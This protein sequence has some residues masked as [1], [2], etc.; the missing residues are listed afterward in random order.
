MNTHAYNEYVIQASLEAG[1]I[2]Q[3]QFLAMQNA[4]QTMPDLNALD[5]LTE[6]EMITAEQRVV[7]EKLIQDA[8]KNPVPPPT[9]LE[10]L[11]EQI[12][13]WIKHSFDQGWDRLFLISGES[14]FGQKGDKTFP[15]PE[16]Q[17]VTTQELELYLESILTEE[18][19][20][21]LYEREQVQ[22]LVQNQHFLLSLSLFKNETGGQIIFDFYPTTIPSFEDK[23]PPEAIR[24]LSVASGGLG[25]IYGH[26]LHRNK[27]A[28]DSAI[29]HLNRTRTTNI[30]Y[31]SNLHLYNHQPLH[32]QIFLYESDPYAQ[33]KV[34]FLE[35]AIH[36]DISIVAMDNLCTNQEAWLIYRLLKQN[37]LVLIS[38][39]VQNEA[40]AF[41]HVANLFSS[42]LPYQQARNLLVNCLR[43]PIASDSLYY[44]G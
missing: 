25:I 7:L 13:N 21:V 42:F 30:L 23:A 35:R 1:W 20:T 9:P 19:T 14:P 32:S 33:P 44:R 31:V 29:D 10:H 27:V 4:L 16:N 11:P 37:R 15:V 6:Q 36:Q 39:N 41:D 34:V 22:A 26:S 12:Q 5:I 3:D 40:H 18:K 28:L 2:N 17:P 24:T 43:M 38:V 8:E